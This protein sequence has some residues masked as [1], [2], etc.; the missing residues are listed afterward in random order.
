MIESRN[1]KLY[2]GRQNSAKFTTEMNKVNPLNSI[3]IN[4]YGNAFKLNFKY[5]GNTSINLIFE[6][7]VANFSKGPIFIKDI[8]ERIQNFCINEEI[9]RELNNNGVTKYFICI[10][11]SAMF[12]EKSVIFKNCTFVM[13]ADTFVRLIRPTGKDTTEE[14]FQKGSLIKKTIDIFNQLYVITINNNC[15]FM[16]GNREKTK[17]NIGKGNFN[18]VGNYTKI[19][20]PQVK[21]MLITLKKFLVLHL[22]SI[23]LLLQNI[24]L[25]TVLDVLNI[26]YSNNTNISKVINEVNNELTN[27]MIYILEEFIFEKFTFFHFDENI[28]STELRKKRI[29]ID[30]Q[31]I[32]FQVR[33]YKNNLI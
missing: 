21:T 12:I 18:V 14:N 26:M 17:N 25:K 24:N 4:N 16:V 20:N 23:S 5:N 10:T 2:K 19:I 32:H 11:K 22:D 28:S 15:N 29:I 30:Y 9:Q 31:I 13:G 8:K 3:T 6:L 1:I 7:S 27:K 33:K